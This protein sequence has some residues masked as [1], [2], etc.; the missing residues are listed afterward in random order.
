MYSA[1]TLKELVQ[2]G[3]KQLFIDLSDLCCVPQTEFSKEIEIFTRRNYP[4]FSKWYMYLLKKLY[5]PNHGYT[6]EYT[7]QESDDYY[8]FVQQIENNSKFVLLPESNEPQPSYGSFV[9][10]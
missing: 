7:A 2:N 5:I 9:S 4:N 1:F 10:L 8:L 3:S 6:E